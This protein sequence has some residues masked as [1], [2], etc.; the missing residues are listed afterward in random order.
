[1]LLR[2][3]IATGLIT[4]FQA[5]LALGH[6]DHGFGHIVGEHLEVI[7]NEHTLSGSIAE[8]PF[9]ATPL[10]KA[11][12]M[13]LFHRTGERTFESTFAKVGEVL[14]AEVATLNALQTE[15]NVHF[16]IT[17]IDPASGRIT[18]KLDEDTFT[19]QLSAEEMNGH[20]YVNPR[21]DVESAGKLY[22]FQLENGQACLGCAT[23]ISFAILS[24]LRGAGK[25]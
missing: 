25:F 24:M 7:Y 3:A 19:I 10:E 11:Y 12:G 2:T 16:E 13:R 1:M 8:R 18:G 14:S 23:K 5:S 15:G 22:S 6:Q 4:L 20:H 21:F 17:Q 9:F